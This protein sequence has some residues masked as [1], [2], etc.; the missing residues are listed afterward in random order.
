MST[1][2]NPAQTPS[3]IFLFVRVLLARSA[4]AS[5]PEDKA[6][7]LR[8]A[9]TFLESKKAKE[10]GRGQLEVEEIRWEVVKALGGLPELEVVAETEEATSTEKKKGIWESEWSRLDDKIRGIEDV[11]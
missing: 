7:P 4:L 2:P 10:V 5:T 6:V 9:W 3:H 8:D 1:A 11:K